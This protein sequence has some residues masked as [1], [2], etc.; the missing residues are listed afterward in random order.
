MVKN[1]A[2]F[3]G[4][5]SA[6][7]EISV[8]TGLF[9]LNVLDKTKFSPI[10]LYLHSDGGIYTSRQMTSV[11]FFKEFCVKKAERVILDGK[12]LLVVGKRQKCKELAIL[13]VAINCCHGGLGEGGGVSALAELS[14]IPLASPSVA[15]SG[16]FLDKALTKVLAKGLNIPTV[17]WIRVRE[18]DYRKRGAFL[19]KNIGTRLSYPVIVKPCMLGSS[20]GIQVA[21]TEEELDQA[22]QTAFELDSVA[23]IEKFLEEKADVNCAAYKRGGEVFVSEP[24][25]ASQGKGVY[26]FEEKYLRSDGER[27]KSGK[28]PLTE[29]ELAQKIRSYTKTLYKKTNLN[30]V[31]R[32]DFLISG[33]NVYL[34][35]VNTVPGSLAYYLFC[36]RLTGAREFFTDLLEEAVNTFEKK[37]T[38][39][40]G[41]LRTVKSGGRKIRL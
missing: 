24:E 26:G 14:G 21:N 30:G 15:P 16:I 11:E 38:L 6:E 17:D 7:R 3:F 12:R 35:E 39:E 25:I 36:D 28:I 31:I 19:I 2:V 41:I 8:L 34:S 27:F 29:K 18:N 32:V 37:K 4:G 40:T 23:V 33:K 5:D 10:P 9:V 13:D 1:V 20:I 22:L